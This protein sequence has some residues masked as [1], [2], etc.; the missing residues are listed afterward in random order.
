[1]FLR[2]YSQKFKI[3]ESLKLRRIK[4]YALCYKNN[5]TFIYGG[6]HIILAFNIEKNMQNLEEILKYYK[7][8]EEKYN[9]K[10][11]KYRKKLIYG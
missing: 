10:S 11:K 4:S 5:E 9:M 8:L 7:Y 3:L 1:M 2:P 6:I